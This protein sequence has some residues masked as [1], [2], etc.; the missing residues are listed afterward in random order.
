MKK[1]IRESRQNLKR[2]LDSV[3]ATD[4]LGVAGPLERALEDAIKLIVG[5]NQAG[6]KL[7]F[8]GNGGSAAIASHMAT[9][10]W[11]NAE[12][13]ALAFNDSVSLT[14]VSN[15][16]GYPYVFEKSIGMFG[17][18]RD[19]LI[20]ISS[21]GKSENI[22]RATLLAREKGLRIITFSGFEPT[23]PLR[24]QGHINFYV[25]AAHYGYVEVIHHSLC[26]CLIDVI[27]KNKLKVE[28]NELDS[29]LSGISSPLPNPPH[30]GGGKNR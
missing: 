26:H 22:L 2:L 25:P 1:D 10:F 12:I 9:D 17:E 20:A 14:C 24:G 7:L 28:T 30:E 6:G 23:N 4:N 29:S 16:H 5:Q 15:D 13:R 27:L 21:S 18:S 8:I 11:K 3:V 19:V